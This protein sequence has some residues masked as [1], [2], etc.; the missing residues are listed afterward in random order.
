MI[1][2]FVENTI[3]SILREVVINNIAN[4]AIL[5]AYEIA[6]VYYYSESGYLELNQNLIKNQGKITTDFG[7]YLVQTLQKLPDYAGELVFR[8]T[9]LNQRQIQRYVDAFNEQKPIKEP[10]FLSTS[11]SRLIA[12][13]F[14]GGNV[15]FEIFSKTG[16]EIENFAKF[17][18]HSSQNEKEVVFLPNTAFYVRAIS[19]QQNLT[20][21]TLREV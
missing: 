9:H 4:D 18:F 7:K 6:V 5:N 19:K 21:I 1:D 15:I 11:K 12:N 10:L 2:E 13:Q 17:G 20:L 14:S 16:K 3:P 8:G